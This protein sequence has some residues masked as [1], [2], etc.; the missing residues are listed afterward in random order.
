MAHNE[1][2]EKAFLCVSY[3]ILGYLGY[4]KVKAAFCDIP[5]EWRE[6]MA[7]ATK[8]DDLERARLKDALANDPE[9]ESAIDNFFVNQLV[10]ELGFD[11]SMENRRLLV[12]RGFNSFIVHG[13]RTRLEKKAGVLGVSE[14]LEDIE[15]YYEYNEQLTDLYIE[16]C[17][18]LALQKTGMLVKMRP[19]GDKGPDLHISTRRL[20]F[21]VEI[22]RFR[23][24]ISLGNK[25]ALDEKN[26][27]L[28]KEMPDKSQNVWSKIDYKVKQLREKNNGIVLLF[29]DDIGFDWIEFEKNVEHMSCFGEKLCAVIFTDKTGIVKSHLKPCA[30]IPD[31][32]LNHNSCK[33]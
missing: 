16:G 24:G 8:V 29:S 22:S 32:E 5:S 31:R 23:A 3:N 30:R 20:S 2:Q 19:Y 7:Y 1:H 12:F 33:R 15:R 9:A 21:D 17:C 25:I 4:E 11:S 26:D 13:L 18:A 14:W 6:R 28:L 27:G 10:R